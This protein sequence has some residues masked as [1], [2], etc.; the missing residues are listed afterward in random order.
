MNETQSTEWRSMRSA[1]KDGTRILVTVRASEQGGAEVDVVKWARPDPQAEPGWIAT[2]SDP[3]ARVV[4]GEGELA[5]WMPLPA[6][7]ASRGTRPALAPY[8]GEE[9]DGS[10]I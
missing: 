3:E 1:P 9:M 6:A 10:A 2:D 5:A 4:Y 8:T 7:V